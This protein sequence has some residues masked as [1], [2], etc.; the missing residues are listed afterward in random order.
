MFSDMDDYDDE[1]EDLLEAAK[2]LVMKVS[3]LH[4]CC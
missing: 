4:R 2:Q 1:V 3:Q